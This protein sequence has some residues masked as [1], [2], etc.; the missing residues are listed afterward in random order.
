MGG[1]SGGGGSGAAGESSEVAMPSGIGGTLS[2]DDGLELGLVV[3]KPPDGERI[4]HP[5]SWIYGRLL[6]D[7]YGEQLVRWNLDYIPNEEVAEDLAEGLGISK[8]EGGKH[9]V[10]IG[11]KFNP[12]KHVYV[13][14][15]KGTW[16]K[17]PYLDLEKALF[18]AKESTPKVMDLEEAL[19]KGVVTSTLEDESSDNHDDYTMIDGY[20]WVSDD[21]TNER[22]WQVEPVTSSNL[23]DAER[24]FVDEQFKIY[25]NNPPNPRYKDRPFLLTGNMI[26]FRTTRESDPI[27]VDGASG[28]NDPLRLAQMCDYLNQKFQTEIINPRKSPVKSVQAN[29]PPGRSTFA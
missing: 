5:E 10:L 16:S 17:D 29:T 27:V 22:Y 12:D 9:T 1:G 7:D 14:T 20:K 15:E 8:H 3:P 21:S 18:E 23:T 24:Q 25:E 13:R 4:T 6:S 2:H 26:L 11:W 28:Y 19:E